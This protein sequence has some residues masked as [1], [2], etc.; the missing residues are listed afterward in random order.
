M[1]A[2]IAEKRDKKSMEKL[3]ESIKFR[4]HSLD[5]KAIESIYDN[6]K[7]MSNLGFLD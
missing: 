2:T 6:Y 3:A 4:P 1:H 7:T 5:L